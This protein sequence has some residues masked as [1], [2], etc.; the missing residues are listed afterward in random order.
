[1]QEKREFSKLNCIWECLS[2][3][4]Y[5]LLVLIFF[6][7]HVA[8][9]TGTSYFWT[10]N[11]VMIPR[12]HPIVSRS[13]LAGE[14]LLMFAAD[15]ATCRCIGKDIYSAFLLHLI[16]PLIVALGTYWQ[17]QSFPHCV[18][19]NVLAEFHKHRP[20]PGEAMDTLKKRPLCAD[21]G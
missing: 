21:L 15:C 9:A 18:D 1:M 7:A 11:C 12:F 14:A 13:L 5:I 17:H 16:A 3:K 2:A 20:V 6:Y 8:K 4:C 19:V 10:Q